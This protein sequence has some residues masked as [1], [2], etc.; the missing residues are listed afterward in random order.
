MFPRQ[1]AVV[2][3]L[4]YTYCSYNCKCQSK[5]VA[6]SVEAIVGRGGVEPCPVAGHHTWLSACLKM[7][8][9]SYSVVMTEWMP[10][11]S[12]PSLPPSLPP[13][14]SPFPPLRFPCQLC[15][16][17]WS[18][19]SSWQDHGARPTWWRTVSNHLLHAQIQYYLLSMS[20]QAPMSVHSVFYLCFLPLFSSLPHF[21]PL[22][23]H[24]FLSSSMLVRDHG[25]EGGTNWWYNW[26]CHWRWRR[27][28]RKVEVIHSLI[29]AYLWH[30]PFSILTHSEALVQKVFDELG[31]EYTDEVH[32]L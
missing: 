23:L 3:S 27:G 11:P 29:N 30:H 31:L 18:P 19:Q 25:F 20:V 4:D 7:G 26:W 21:L 32:P 8:L 12:H 6:T 14:F 28:W 2:M 22:L 17:H 1:R 10:S 16:L 5:L 24:P 15:C 9:H 13:S